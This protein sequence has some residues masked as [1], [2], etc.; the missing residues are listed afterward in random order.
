MT[1]NVSTGL[2]WTIRIFSIGALIV[3]IVEV[4]LSVR[5]LNIGLIFNLDWSG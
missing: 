4:S 3:G 1:D 2:N 5:I